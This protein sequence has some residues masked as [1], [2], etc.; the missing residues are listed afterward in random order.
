VRGAGVTKASWP[1]DVGSFPEGYLMAPGRLPAF[2]EDL[3]EEIEGI[4][5]LASDQLRFCDGISI[6]GLAG[7]IGPLAQIVSCQPE[8]R[9][10]SRL[11]T[12]Q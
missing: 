9:I 6:S 5:A 2:D 7:S 10:S 3:A 12:T 4:G 1:E 11:Q 8:I